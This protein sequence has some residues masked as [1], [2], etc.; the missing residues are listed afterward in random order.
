MKTNEFNSIKGILILFLIF[1]IAIGFNS[2]YASE[3]S[4]ISSLNS[5]S[6]FILEE[7]NS[8]DVDNNGDLEHKSILA[9]SVLG[10]SN[11][12][13]NANASI[14]NNIVLTT[15]DLNA[16]YK[17]KNFTAKL[18][19]SNGNPISGAKVAFTVSSKTYNKTTDGSGTAYLMINLSP[20]TYN[21]TSSFVSNEND[22]SLVDKNTIK[23]T[24]KKITLETSNLY[25]KYG[26]SDK[27]QVK[28][29][30]N[31]NPIANLK[32][33]LKIGSKTY[34]KIT[35][36]EGIVNLSINLKIGKYPINSS[37]STN[38]NYYAS[39]VSN[40]V[41]VSSQNPYKL[42]LLKWG[43]K[44][45]I[46]KNSVLWKNIPK[47]SLTSSIVSYCNN[48]TPLIQFG[49]GSGKK[50]F[51]VAGVHGNELASQAAAFKLINSIYNS[52]SKLSGTVYIIPVLCPKSTALN[53]R[54]YNGVNLDGVADKK[55]TISYKLVQYAKSLKVNAVGDFHCTR[56]GGDPGKNVAMGTYSPTASSATLAKYIAKTTG[57]SK[58]IYKKAGVEYPGAV[59]DVFNLA[60]ITSV[61]CEVVTPHG[62][63]ASGSVNRS[64]NLMK[65]FLK[66]YGM[67]F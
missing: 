10:E 59:E 56:P 66:Y 43:S 5:S 15:D 17:S 31:D 20:G 18:T 47:S 22:L 26:N 25:K 27:F 45:N 38:K 61:T 41:T 36:A 7:G 57:Y 50:V 51:I 34:Y 24:K 8:V 14:S 40:N 33:A 21:I 28:A 65:A 49:N 32:I 3:S 54:Y 2:V 11:S 23:I 52:K 9:K 35:D 60:K 29:S 37:L 58:L 4:D 42:S 64:L 62:K 12:D 63:I 39:S 30:D 16:S 46:K 13:S 1:F 67:K 6:N 48:G 53:Q 19:D 55:G 44:G